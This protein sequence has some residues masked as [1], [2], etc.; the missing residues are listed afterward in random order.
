MDEE[1]INELRMKKKKLC[2]VLGRWCEVVGLVSDIGE[3]TS[4]HFQSFVCFLTTNLNL[5]KSQNV[6]L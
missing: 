2:Y 5:N 3:P 4:Y 6:S 1:E